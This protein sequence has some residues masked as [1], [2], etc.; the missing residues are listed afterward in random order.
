VSKHPGLNI[1][2][3]HAILRAF[4][5]EYLRIYARSDS[6]SE[7]LKMTLLGEL[8]FQT[9]DIPLSH[10]ITLITGAGDPHGS[11]AKIS[12]VSNLWCQVKSKVVKKQDRNNRG[13]RGEHGH[14]TSVENY[15]SEAGDICISRM[16]KHSLGIVECV[17]LPR[18]KETTA[19]WCSASNSKN[20]YP[21]K[22]WSDSA[23]SV[24]RESF[25]GVEQC[26]TVRA[27]EAGSY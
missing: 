17:G 21:L 16:W 23:Q 14:Q 13:I 27:T 5:Q 6:R 20:R 24:T 2:E 19:S 22:R 8:N 7:L 18:N 3:H 4:Y 11:L 10:Q 1:H 26:R 15:S 25:N 9:S 12:T